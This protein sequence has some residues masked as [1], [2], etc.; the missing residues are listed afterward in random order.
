MTVVYRIIGSKAGVAIDIALRNHSVGIN[1]KCVFL[2]FF[3]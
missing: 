3:L 1:D 2:V